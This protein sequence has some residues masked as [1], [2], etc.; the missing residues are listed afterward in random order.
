[1]KVLLIG[2]SE[3]SVAVLEMYMKRNYPEHQTVVIARSFGANLRLSLPNLPSEHMNAQAMIINLDGVGMI[4]HS[5][6]YAKKLRRFIGVRAAIIVARGNLLLWQA[7]NILP[8]QFAFFL[9]SPFDK[10]SM[11]QTV[12]A[13]LQVA[14][15]AKAHAAEFY[16]ESSTEEVLDEVVE[17]STPKPKRQHIPSVLHDVIDKYFNVAQKEVLHDLLDLSLITKPAKLTAGSQVLYLNRQK[18]MA[19]VSNIGR[20][21]DYCVVANNCQILSNI[22]AIEFIDEKEFEAL[23]QQA[24]N[25]GYQKHA[26]NSFLWQMQSALLPEKIYVDDHNLLLKMRYMPNLGQMGAVPDYVHAITSVS[27]IAPRSLN[28]LSEMSGLGQAGKPLVN[29]LILLAILSG[30]ADEEILKK[31]YD[32]AEHAIDVPAKNENAG[33]KK[34]IGTGFLRRLIEKLNTPISQL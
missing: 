1:M 18:N 23:V 22:V 3:Q 17:K 19:L 13:L 26:F 10:Q 21:I 27:L 34:A 33:V 5:E 28:Q 24:P 12:A 6:E 14:P 8:E 9:K 7:S 4:G 2:F 32:N 15:T 20:L 25:N 30:A 31:C 29:R 16:H 11:T